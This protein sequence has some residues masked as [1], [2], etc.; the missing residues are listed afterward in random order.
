MDLLQKMADSWKPAVGSPPVGLTPSELVKL[1]A[2]ASWHSVDLSRVVYTL[3]GE[4]GR[5]KPGMDADLLIIMGHG[6]AYE[7]ECLTFAHNTPSYIPQCL[8]PRNHTLKSLHITT[9]DMNEDNNNNDLLG[10]AAWI[11]NDKITIET[12]YI[13]GSAFPVSY[14][15]Y[16]TVVNSDTAPCVLVFTN[17]NPAAISSWREA[18]ASEADKIVWAHLQDHN[19]QFYANTHTIIC[20]ADVL[21]MHSHAHIQHI[22]V[23]T[24]SLAYL[25]NLDLAVFPDCKTLKIKIDTSLPT[26]NN[27]RTMAIC[28]LPDLAKL[29][30]NVTLLQVGSDNTAFDSRGLYYMLGCPIFWARWNHVTG[31]D[32]HCSKLTHTEINL[33][34]KIP[35]LLRFSGCQAQLIVISIAETGQVYS[36]K[37][38]GGLEEYAAA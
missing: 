35:W 3:P 32:F 38:V 6:L 37:K 15:P 27:S 13:T 31:L 20:H 14:T 1:D 24:P 4:D 16:P 34:A 22:H 8:V 12:L 9:L 25:K 7:L 23:D 2:G 30:P 26:G 36:F 29:F 28:I 5:E 33:I 19:L 11:K 17:V 21:V 18:P 10:I